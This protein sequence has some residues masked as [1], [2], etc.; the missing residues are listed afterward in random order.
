MAVV[1]HPGPIADG[2]TGNS[3]R[4]AFAAQEEHS[5]LYFSGFIMPVT[6][7]ER[8]EPAAGAVARWSDQIHY[9]VS[10]NGRGVERFSRTGGR[11]T[12]G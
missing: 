7:R 2:T 10:K 5:G 3:K 12:G 9:R 11:G 6:A 1:D 4:R 8:N